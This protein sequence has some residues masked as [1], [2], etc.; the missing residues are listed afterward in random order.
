MKT[1]GMYYALLAFVVFGCS[2]TPSEDSEIPKEEESFYNA[3]YVLLQRNNEQLSVQLLNA[4]EKT[5]NLNSAQSTFE[6]VPLPEISFRKGTTYAYYTELTE[7]SGQL[8]IHDF[9]DDTAIT[10]D[11]FEDL[12][13]CN[14]KTTS[15]AVAAEKVYVSYVKEETS[16]INKYFVRVIDLSVAEVNH[17][18]IELDKKPLQMDYTNG[19][20]FVWTNDLDIT[21]E[22]ALSVFD[23]VSQ[24]V[25]HEIG[26]GYDVERIFAD[27]HQNMIIAYQELH[28][29]LNSTTMNMQYIRYED[30]KEP[31]FFGSKSNSFDGAGR[32]F[33]IRP[34]AEYSGI[35]SIYDFSNNLALLY[36]YENFL[37]AS[38]LE[39][40][41]NIGE[42]TMVGY[43]D[44]NKVMLI[45][46][47]KKDDVNKGGL[48]RIQLEP[49]PEFLDNLNING[50]PC[51]I[52]YQN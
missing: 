37:T 45:G 6:N 5:M 42:T 15:I 24:T 10:I 12:L 3:D 17:V 14:L 7:C 46:Y 36:Y 38:Q 43:D 49:D 50:I 48:L 13:D 25:I 20:L 28:T 34:E 16:K 51:Q 52:F 40:E 33:Y 35:P 2:S 23:M 21:N 44:V 4:T 18:D 8:T 27:T 22:N 9:A 39:F 29:V 1:Y 31:L 30:G 47:Q 32:L 11:V 26:L 41:F 19:R